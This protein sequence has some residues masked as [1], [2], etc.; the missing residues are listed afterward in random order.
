MHVM[1]MYVTMKLEKQNVD[2][3]IMR[4]NGKPFQKKVAVLY[5]NVIMK[6]VVLRRPCVS[7][8]IQPSKLAVTIMQIQ[9]T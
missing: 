5:T 4:R 1:N 6:L 7:A 8:M 3:G 2:G 9:G